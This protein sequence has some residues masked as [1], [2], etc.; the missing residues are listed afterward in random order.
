MKLVAN[1]S[2]NAKIIKK[3]DIDTFCGGVD[4]PIVDNPGVVKADFNG[5]KLKD[6]AVLLQFGEAVEATHKF[7]TEEVPYKKV[8]VALV[9]FIAGRNGKFKAVTLMEKHLNDAN[10]P[11]NLYIK[12]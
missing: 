7:G 4:Y 2:S 12:K 8:K 1:F 3:A 10:Y 6:F 5:D 9:A 11:L